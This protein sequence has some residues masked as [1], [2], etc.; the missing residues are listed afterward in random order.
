MTTDF[1]DEENEMFNDVNMNREEFMKFISEEK[2]QEFVRMA[3]G[4]GAIDDIKNILKQMEKLNLSESQTKNLEFQ[5]ESKLESEFMNDLEEISEVIF[6][7]G[8]DM[9]MDMIKNQDEP[10]VDNSIH[11][12]HGGFRLLGGPFDGAYVMPDDPIHKCREENLPETVNSGKVRFVIA[13]W[14][15]DIKLKDM[16]MMEPLSRIVYEKSL[17]DVNEDVKLKQFVY[18][19][20]PEYDSFAD[21][22]NEITNFRLFYGHRRGGIQ[23]KLVI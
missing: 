8:E 15:P 19:P 20:A 12:H 9:D 1:E 13:Y 14:P 2:F 6:K 18:E 16:N 7:N 11:S 22:K 21:R 17:V 5:P 10:T 23:T 3:Y 4:D